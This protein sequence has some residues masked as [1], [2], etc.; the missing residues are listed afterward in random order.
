MSV[1]GRSVRPSV[2]TG[3]EKNQFLTLPVSGSK[4][5]IRKRLM[6]TQ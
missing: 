1:S 6:S 2:T 4:R 3:S 5:W